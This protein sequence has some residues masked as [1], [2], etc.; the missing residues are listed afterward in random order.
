[1]LVVIDEDLRDERLEAG[2]EREEMKMR[3]PE[4]MAVLG[5]QHVARR[6][7]RSAPDILPASPNGN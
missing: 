2:L 3:R 6:D 1:M 4:G 7:R 5:A